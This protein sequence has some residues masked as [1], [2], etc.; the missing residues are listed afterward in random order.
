MF[1]LHKSH[2]R[3]KYGVC[4]EETKVGWTAVARA[5]ASCA[6][7]LARAAQLLRLLCLIHSLRNC[8][9][10]FTMLRSC[11]LFGVFQ[12]S[13]TGLDGSLFEFC[14][15]LLS[16]EREKRRL[17]SHLNGVRPKWAKMAG[18]QDRPPRE[19]RPGPHGMCVDGRVSPDISR[20]KRGVERGEF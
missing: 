16:R 18:V 10:Q 7:C 15:Q 13:I 19:R 3:V 12:P 1:T 9:W 11:H 6:G 2:S 8:L 4:R 17:Q 20:A 5:A 14:T